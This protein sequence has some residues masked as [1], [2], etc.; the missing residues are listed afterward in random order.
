MTGWTVAIPT[1][2]RPETL[3]DKTLATLARAGV[4]P[5]KITVWCSDPAEVDVYGRTLTPGT[6]GRIEA[7]E[8]GVGPNRNR[9]IE[10]NIGRRVLYCDDD[11]RAIDQRA[12]AKRLKPVTDLPALVD[13]AFE[14]SA[15]AGARLWGVYPVHNPFYMAP[16]VTTDLRYIIG[17]LYGVDVHGDECE[18]VT[19]EDKEDFERSIRC[20]LA[21]GATV[22]LEFVAPETRYYVEPGG[23]QETRTPE[24]IEANARLLA[25]RYPDLCQYTVSSAGRPELA[26]RDRR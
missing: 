26:L 8:E 2:R 14:V 6:Y 15:R 16:K 5:A 24:R 3:R 7:G 20:Y 18:L 19:M 17:C 22:R 9:I 4:D 12:S 1:F 10:A 25:E 11:L 13:R 21:D 23:L